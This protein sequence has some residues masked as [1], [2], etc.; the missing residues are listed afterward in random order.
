MNERENGAGALMKMYM[1]MD[2]TIHIDENLTYMLKSTRRVT[3]GYHKDE[4]RARTSGV[5]VMNN[6]NEECADNMRLDITEEN[7]A[8]EMGIDAEISVKEAVEEKEAD[9]ASEIRQATEKEADEKEATEK[10]AAAKEKEGA[11]KIDAAKKKEQARKLEA[12]KKKE[13]VEKLAAAKKGNKA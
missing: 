2:D 3:K 7:E 9:K 6:G 8:T 1:E 11:E 4:E 12:A 10:E 13:K 5:L